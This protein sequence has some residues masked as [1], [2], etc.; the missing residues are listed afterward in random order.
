LYMFGKQFNGLNYS[1]NSQSEIK[2]DGSFSFKGVEAGEVEIAA[3]TFPQIIGLKLAKIEQDGVS[4]EKVI[5]P[6]GKSLKNLLV[7]VRYG[8]CRARGE[9]RIENGTIPPNA[10]IRLVAKPTA[11]GRLD[12]V[13]AIAD[14]RGKFL[15]EGLTPEEY[16]VGVA[17]AERQQDW[18]RETPLNFL[19]KSRITLTNGVDGQLI[20]TVN[21]EQNP[22]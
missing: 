15:L 5:I 3:I 19:A 8:T 11:S 16:E 2:E 6:E 1:T 13:Y 9:V 4:L 10:E 21:L 18:G 14:E 12:R 7:T 17:I 22:K 20:F